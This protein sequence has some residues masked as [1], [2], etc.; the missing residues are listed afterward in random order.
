MFYLFI[1]CLIIMILSYGFMHR[2]GLVIGLLDLVGLVSNINISQSHHMVRYAILLCFRTLAN[3]RCVFGRWV[4]K[5]GCF[6]V[7]AGLGITHYHN[8][9]VWVVYFKPC[10]ADMYCLDLIH[11]SIE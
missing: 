7:L 1:Y 6:P 5:Q 11:E 8:V 10:E 4:R 9:L 3:S 2:F